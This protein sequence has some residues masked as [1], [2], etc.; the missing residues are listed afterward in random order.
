MKMKLVK[1]KGALQLVLFGIL[2]LFCCTFMVGF[3]NTPI[4][5]TFMEP[6]TAGA[7]EYEVF[8]NAVKQFEKTHP[9]VKVVL[10]ALDTGSLRTKLTVQMAAGN[11]PDVS[12]CVLS[13]AR[14]FMAGNKIAD[15]RPIINDKKHS[16]F[17]KW[18][19]DKV[20][21]FAKYKDGRIMMFP[22]EASV[23]GMFY[24]KAMFK[25]YGW[26]PPKT[27]DD[28]IRLAKKARKEGKYAMVTSGKDA[29]FSW[30]CS[31]LLV[32]TG[33][34]KNAEALTTGDAQDQWNDPKYGFVDAMRKFKQLVDAQA[35]PPGIM[36][37]ST[38]ECDQMFA[39]EEVAMD[40][41]GAF[42]I[43]NFIDA[44]GKA[45]VKKLGRISFP[46]MKDMPNGEPQVVVGGILTG[47]ILAAG[48]PKEKQDLVV[49]LVK[50]VDS[51]ALYKKMM[52]LGSIP[53]PGKVR[54]DKTKVLPI[55]NDFFEAFQKAPGYIPSADTLAPPEVDNAI[56]KTA[57]SGIVTGEFTVDQAVAEVQKAAL[58]YLQSKKK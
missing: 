29:R 34:R 16:E 55:Y 41:E 9:N 30:L 44:G 51:P 26:Q 58:N 1:V 56:K 28:L 25:K 6:E 31:A 43:G 7:P 50:A 27:F 32:R 46:A 4:T 15:L 11:P 2:L 23:G 5:I 38:S 47:Y 35:F 37:M 36:G 33:G 42:K 53:Y 19:P 14:E 3:N 8:N 39:R 24:N 45:F 20:L 21:N 54:Y 10:N 22:R 48:M 49:E 52:E 12:W 18:F 17:K 57:M 13:Y 40:Y